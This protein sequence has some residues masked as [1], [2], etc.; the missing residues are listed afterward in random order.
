MRF[1]DEKFTKY[2]GAYFLQSL[3]ASGAVL[4]V[5]VLLDAIHQEAIVASLGAT[6][7]TIFA[8]PC[9]AAARPRVVVPGYVIGAAVGTACHGLA[10]YGIGD[11]MLGRYLTM[12]FAS[13]AV[14]LTILLMT[15]TNCEHA[16]AAGVALGLVIQ[17]WSLVVVTVVLVGVVVL[18]LVKSALDRWLKD[19]V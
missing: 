19:L 2:P 1:L 15:V 12:G 6:A 4:V 16:P 5:L 7:F 18:C 9:T 14:G 17:Q 3:L 11:P 13:L 10:A 8:M